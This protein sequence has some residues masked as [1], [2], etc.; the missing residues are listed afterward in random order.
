MPLNDNRHISKA[1]YPL[2]RP[3]TTEVNSSGTVL[4]NNHLFRYSI[5]CIDKILPGKCTKRTFSLKHF[6]INM[7]R[8]TK[9]D[10]KVK[11]K[12]KPYLTVE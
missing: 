2:T 10:S 4:L 11:P 3:S 8:L 6:T 7:T 9:G 12:E 5:I 1:S